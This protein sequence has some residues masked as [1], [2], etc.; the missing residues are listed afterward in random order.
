LRDRARGIVATI[1][2]VSEAK[3]E[4]ALRE[5]GGEV[6]PAIL[7]ACGVVNMSEAAAWLAAAEGRI[8]DAL[9]R[10][11]INRINQGRGPEQRSEA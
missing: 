8:D 1:A 4:T 11:A 6:K 10:A 5:A 9:R 2:S 7:I 3:A